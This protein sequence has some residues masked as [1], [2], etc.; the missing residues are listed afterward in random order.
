MTTSNQNQS[1]T[2]CTPV[3]SLLVSRYCLWFITS[4]AVSYVT[5]YFPCRQTNRPRQQATPTASRMVARFAHSPPCN[6]P[7]SQRVFAYGGYRIGFSRTTNRF[8]YWQAAV[9]R[10][11]GFAGSQLI[12]GCDRYVKVLDVSDESAR[13]LGPPGVAPCVRRLAAGRVCALS[14]PARRVLSGGVVVCASGGVISLELWFM[15]AS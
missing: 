1:S 7:D 3:V 13:V 8:H 15:D 4:L 11:L 5:N 9:V 6:I 12:L 14:A 2:A 10:C